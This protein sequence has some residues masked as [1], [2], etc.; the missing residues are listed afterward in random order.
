[1][2]VRI[3]GTKV[4]ACDSGDQLPLNS[5]VRMSVGGGSYEQLFY[6]NQADVDPTKLLYVKDLAVGQTVDF[7][8]RY[9]KSGGD[10]SPFYT[11]KNSSRQVIALING[12]TPP[13]TFPLYQSAALAS[14]L[15]PYLDSSG[16]VNIG[17]LSVLVVMELGQTDQSKSCF[18]LQDQ[19]LLVTFSDKHPN[20][21]HGNNLYGVDPSNP[22][23]GQGG[24]NGEIPPTDDIE[25]HPAH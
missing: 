6:G 7:G 17:P 16:K 18:D 9:V 4:T 8:G 12:D 15:K 10:W 2:Q 23:K 22:G 11:T 13:T 3:V 24:P 21:G 25:I 20:N 14:Y 19:V 5:E 1:M